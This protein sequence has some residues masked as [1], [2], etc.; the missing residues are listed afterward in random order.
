M[1][2]LQLTRRER[3]MR[4]YRQCLRTAFDWSWNRDAWYDDVSQS[5]WRCSHDSF[6]SQAK[7]IR[8]RFEENKE[9]VDLNQIDRVIA[10]GE[11]E[12]LEKRHPDPYKRQWA[13]HHLYGYG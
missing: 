5:L 7:D 6:L 4:L 12:L 8:Q 13:T 1:S 2:A 10:A 11:A 9:L 3:V